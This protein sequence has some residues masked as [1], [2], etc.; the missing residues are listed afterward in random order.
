MFFNIKQLALQ[1]VSPSSY[2]EIGVATSLSYYLVDPALPLSLAS[3]EY[4]IDK[5]SGRDATNLI[6]WTTISIDGVTDDTYTFDVTLSGD[7]VNTSDTIVIVFKAT[8]TDD[9][10]YYIKDTEVVPI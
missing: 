9:M 8:D 6:P 2:L 10:E 1:R 7:A 5:L 3:L 4:K